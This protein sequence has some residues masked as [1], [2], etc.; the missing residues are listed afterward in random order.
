MISPALARGVSFCL[1]QG[2]C[3][4]GRPQSSLLAVSTATR[5]AG[6]PKPAAPLLVA[7]RRN[8]APAKRNTGSRNEDVSFSR[9]AWLLSSGKQDGFLQRGRPDDLE[10]CPAVVV[11]RSKRALQRRLRSGGSGVLFAIRGHSRRKWAFTGWD[12]LGTA[13]L[14]HSRAGHSCHRDQLVS[15]YTLRLQ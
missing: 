4:P 12:G 14:G 9:L 6:S 10:G 15:F 2:R 11:G 13:A 8:E 5:S 7:A 3:G 1:R